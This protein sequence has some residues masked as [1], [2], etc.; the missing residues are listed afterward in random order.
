MQIDQVNNNERDNL[1][2]NWAIGSQGIND[3]GPVKHEDHG[4][5][6]KVKSGFG[7]G[8]RATP[9]GGASTRKG[10]GMGGDWANNDANDRRSPHNRGGSNSPS[11]GAWGARH[12]SNP[13][14]NIKDERERTLGGGGWGAPDKDSNPGAGG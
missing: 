12:D 3:S 10:P 14:T 9:G 4:F 8:Q 13:G 7:R 1:G 11:G 6:S 2:A 5:S